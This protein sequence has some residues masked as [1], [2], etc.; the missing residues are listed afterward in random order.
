[1]IK[2]LMKI[3]FVFSAYSAFGNLCEDIFSENHA[4]NFLRWL[5]LDL[6]IVSEKDLERWVETGTDLDQVVQASQKINQLQKASIIEAIIKLNI[7]VEERKKVLDYLQEWKKIKAQQNEEIENRKSETK[8]V[9][10][11][12]RLN[13]RIESK[14]S[15]KSP[16]YTLGDETFYL[17]QK[18]PDDYD[19]DQ[20]ITIIDKNGKE[21]K[22]FLW[23]EPATSFLENMDDIIAAW[24]FI[25]DGIKYLATIQFTL[26]VKAALI[27]QVR[28]EGEENPIIE[29]ELPTSSSCVDKD[30][31]SL[32][33][34]NNKLVFL[35]QKSQTVDSIRFLYLD[36][37]TRESKPYYFTKVFPTKFFALDS[38]T[39]AI[40]FAQF[41]E[42]N[43]VT[44]KLVIPEDRK[45]IDLQKTEEKL[46][47]K[48]NVRRFKQVESATH[49]YLVY[50]RK[51]AGNNN[52]VNFIVMMINKNTSSVENTFSFITPGKFG[53]VR[54][55]SRFTYLNQDYLVLVHEEGLA[56]V[57]TENGILVGSYSFSGLNR[58]YYGVRIA[59]EKDGTI[60]AYL[61]YLASDAHQIYEEDVYQLVGP[62]FK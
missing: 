55:Q 42:D 7:Q 13:E 18:A 59:T 3:I 41:A 61:A 10:A 37:R 9:I 50:G 60:R 30:A 38:G 4:N 8:N 57:D 12:I 48:L 28:I 44:F 6:D 53:L 47:S 33:V 22:N 43:S 21:E 40:S 1:M 39:L 49:H 23:T 20:A 62:V 31:L 16:L 11:P 34:L 51:N 14:L 19:H 35:Y 54:F 27:F 25:E 56:I 24:I 58:R 52:P 15:I 45:T 32:K 2:N 36:L 17:T 26:S 29:A 5:Y 46:T